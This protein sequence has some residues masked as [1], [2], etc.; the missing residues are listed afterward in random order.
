MTTGGDFNYD[1]SFNAHENISKTV[2]RIAN[3]VQNARKKLSGGSPAG[4]V[5]DP[6]MVG[7]DL[8]KAV[9]IPESE[10]EKLKESTRRSDVYTTDAEQQV[11]ANREISDSI[12]L[13]RAE[14]EAL[15]KQILKAA[16]A[17]EA[18]FQE[19]K[20]HYEQAILSS[21]QYQQALT[22]EA[23]AL[24]EVAQAKAHAAK[25][26]YDIDLAPF[27]EDPRAIAKAR[28][29]VDVEG[30][31]EQLARGAGVAGL[32]VAVDPTKVQKV[33][34]EFN[35]LQRSVS[36]ATQKLMGMRVEGNATAR[37]LSN[38]GQVIDGLSRTV[39]RLVQDEKLFLDVNDQMIASTTS[40]GGS[41]REFGAALNKVSTDLIVATKATKDNSNANREQEIATRRL[42]TAVKNSYEEAIR[43]KAAHKEMGVNASLSARRLFD[44]EQRLRQLATAIHGTAKASGYSSRQLRL[45]ANEIKD[46][47]QEVARTTNRMGFMQDATIGVQNKMR[48]LSSSMQGAMLGMSAMNLD[49]MGLAFSLIFLQFASEMKAALGFAF[50]TAAIMGVWKAFKKWRQVQ[51]EQ[52]QANRTWATLTGS[53]ASLEVAT[54]K[55]EKYTSGLAIATRHEEE[56]TKALVQAQLQLRKERLEAT[57]QAMK[58][59][60]ASFLT[61]RGYGQ[62]YDD[63]VQSMISSTVD[64][65]KDGTLA[66][67]SVAMSMNDLV[68]TGDNYL[69]YIREFGR[70]VKLTGKGISIFAPDAPVQYMDSIG[71]LTTAFNDLGLE[72]GDALKV[73]LGQDPS[74]NLEDLS[75]YEELSA[76]V[77]RIFNETYGDGGQLIST[78]DGFW[79]Q[80]GKLNTNE[81]SI[82]NK[83]W[84]THLASEEEAIKNSNIL[85]E[86]EEKVT[87]IGQIWRSG[88]KDTGDEM[89]VFRDQIATLMGEINAAMIIDDIDLTNLKASLTEIDNLVAEKKSRLDEVTTAQFNTMVAGFGSP[90]SAYGYQGSSLGTS[91]DTS[92]YIDINVTANNANEISSVVEGAVDRS[93]NKAK[94]H[95]GYI[96]PS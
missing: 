83:I 4:G 61:A 40:A 20:A 75:N 79:T 41:T 23:S 51:K 19:F 80:W 2:D 27:R 87:S 73:V 82:I 28:E 30:S 57:P 70:S 54:K 49:V 7:G 33:D 85:G 74:V 21:E 13:I 53:F 47:G 58:V 67:D 35:Q 42:N 39:D 81:M 90:L 29:R 45:Q 62:E 14:M 71:D 96:D 36:N 89:V 32:G 26:P 86:W 84:G 56:A 18:Q 11:G 94:G 9:S 16:Q 25:E 46:L 24:H 8:S 38:L 55:A 48:R 63:A 43:S 93:I 37:Q 17:Q 60:L 92:Y 3:R 50:L 10:T 69:A 6:T 72:A 66:F 65:A 5:P 64:Y 95:S 22:Q 77:V 52:E 15:E 31:A 68:Q 76:E 88:I 34:K 12:E 91:V 59:A 44:L 1:I 78:L